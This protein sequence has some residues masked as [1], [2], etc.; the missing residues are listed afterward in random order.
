ML[1]FIIGVILARLLTPGAYGLVGMVLVFSGFAN[2]FTDLGFGAALIQK[3]D[4][5]EAHCST[6]F[7][8]NVI[9]GAIMMLLF[10]AAAPLLGW[11]YDQPAL[12]PLTLLVSTNFLIGSFNTVQSS[13]LKK[14]LDFKKLA[15]IDLTTLAVSGG[16]SI[17]LA[18]LGFG[19]WSLALQSVCATLMSVAIMWALSPWRPTREINFA[20]IKELLKFSAN[21]LGFNAFNYW[22]RNGDNLLV[23]RFLGAA[24]LGIYVKSYGLMLLPLQMVSRTIG[25]VMFPAF[26]SIQNDKERVARVYLDV[27]RTVALITFPM[28]IGLWAVVDHFVL[29]LFGERWAEMIP[30]LGVL[31]LVGMC[32]S[33]G[34]LNGNLYLSQGRSD[35]QF[36]VGIVVGVIGLAAIAIGLKWG[37]VG[38]A[39]AYGGASLV[40]TYPTI[41][42]AASLVNLTF[43]DVAKNLLSIFL[44][45]AA[46][47]AVLLGVDHILPFSWSH[48]MRL[49]AEVPLGVVTYLLLITQFRVR[50]YTSLQNLAAEQWGLRF[51][52]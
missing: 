50:A 40:L 39:W 8:L 29:T 19:V 1:A 17:T 2:I 11:F 35:L 42:I 36:R 33:I 10:M 41:K 52:H 38:V 37:L 27:T 12:V 30:I 49:L 14:R 34:T 31:C 47:G 4:V 51:N 22:L 44:C 7:W 45:A 21:L 46:M 9:S 25:S 16:I 5:T 26:S 32:Q 28:M 18:L 13:L 23:G 20:A 24:A 15:M 6:V 3:K 43:A 48:S